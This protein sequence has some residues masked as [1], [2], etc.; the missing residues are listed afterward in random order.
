[1]FSTQHAMSWNSSY[2]LWRST[3]GQDRTENPSFQR[4]GSS[5]NQTVG[6][7]RGLKGCGQPIMFG[8]QAHDGPNDV[9]SGLGTMT[10]IAAETLQAFPEVL[11]WAPV[12][13]SKSG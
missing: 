10:I 5:A 2:A 7:D 9:N 12:A 6:E 4:Y 1:M 8:F 13:A 3:F 11:G